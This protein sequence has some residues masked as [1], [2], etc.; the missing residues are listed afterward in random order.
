MRSTEVVDVIEAQKERA[1]ASLIKRSE[2]E[3]DAAVISFLRGG[4]LLLLLVHET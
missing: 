4:D 3:V 1:A 2:H